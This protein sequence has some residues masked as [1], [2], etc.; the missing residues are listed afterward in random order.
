MSGVFVWIDHYH[1][2]ALPAAWEALGAGRQVA[3]ALGV[4]LTALVFGASVADLTQ[5]AFHNGADRVIQADDATLKDFR[6]EAYA[7]LLTEV[8][9]THTPNVVLAGA[10][11]RGRE[12]LASSAAD[13][14]SALLP[15]VTELSVD[16][17]NLK[18]T[19]P[20]YAGKVLSTVIGRGATQFA[21]LR[22][23]AFTALPA[24]TARTGEVVTVAAVLAESAIHAQI[25]GFEESK[26]E[27]SLTDA[28]I[29]VSGGRGVGGPEGFKPIQ[30]LADVLG[31]AVGASRATVDAGWIPYA[32]QVGQT[33][34]TV[35]PDLYIAVGISGAIQHQ[36]GMR[37]SKVIVAINKDA[38]AAIFKLAQY[39]IV[40]DLAKVLP[41][42][43]QAFKDKLGK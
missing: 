16:N 17:G 42:L 15:E 18:A 37:G 20:T 41:A 8:V 9:K 19:H 22:S 28:R 25:T 24:D 30:E 14:D 40:G 29:V 26:G 12:L 5:A 36:A 34:K 1:G 3:T 43:T 35:N 6:L 13:T 39:G 7:A 2:R 31:G 38:D 21:T 10:T 11:A 27:V 32:Y 4:P 23:R 33:G